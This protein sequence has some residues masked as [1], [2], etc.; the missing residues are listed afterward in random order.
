[1]A[2]GWGKVTPE[3]WQQAKDAGFGSDE[4]PDGD[5][6]VEAAEF[7]HIDPSKSKNGL[8]TYILT[9]FVTAEGNDPA[10]V[11]KKLELAYKYD[12]APK[13]KG[14]E[15]M[16]AISLTAA[17]KTCEAAGVDPVMDVSGF[18]DVPGTLQMIAQVK[19]RFVLAVSHRTHEGKTYVETG[20]PRSIA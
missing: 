20:N 6:A 17:V 15:Q 10:F 9:T 14:R 8:G 12:P 11:G 3:Q 16:N 19:A 2:L 1:M 4:V 18:Q 5:Y 13:E 7:R